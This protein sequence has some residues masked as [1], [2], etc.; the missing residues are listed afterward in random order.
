MKTAMIFACVGALWG[1][2]FSVMVAGTATCLIAVFR[3]QELPT[4]DYTREFIFTFVIVFSVLFA[5]IGACV[6]GI[7]DARS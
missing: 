1:I 4:L 7:C 6:E 2:A 5:A 3:F